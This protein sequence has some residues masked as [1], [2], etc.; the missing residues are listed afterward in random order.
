MPNLSDLIVT[1]RGILQDESF[2]EDRLITLFNTGIRRCAYLVRLPEL[3]SFG[4]FETDPITTSVVIPEDWDYSRSLYD[5]ST[6]TKQTISVLS[7]MGLLRSKEPTIDTQ[8]K[9]GD[10]EFITV[11]KGYIVYTPSPSELTLVTCK[12]FKNPVPL[13]EDEDFPTCLPEHLQEPLLVN[14]ALWKCFESIEDGIEGDKVNTVYYK[15]EFNEAIE[16]LSHM[17]EEGQSTLDPIRESSWI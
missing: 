4:S 9:I 5:A 17:F 15:N 6:P 10:I 7:S 2:D 8:V 13:V 14:F 1:V 11:R 3:E 12:F 16:E